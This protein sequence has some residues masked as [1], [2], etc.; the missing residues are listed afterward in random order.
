MAKKV[1]PPNPKLAPTINVWAANES[2][3]A[4]LIHPVSKLR[5]RPDIN[6]PIAWPH[7]Q[8]TMRRIADGD[9]LTEPPGG[10]VESTPE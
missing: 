6:Q 5:F 10:K 7:D 1:T 9:L 3:R 8:Y 4:N 2:V